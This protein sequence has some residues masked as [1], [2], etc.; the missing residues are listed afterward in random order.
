MIWFYIQILYIIYKN[1]YIEN[2]LGS[3][4]KRKM[5]MMNWDSI[6]LHLTSY[7]N[8]KFLKI[9]YLRKFWTFKPILNK[10]PTSLKFQQYSKY[11]LYVHF[12]NFF[13]QQR[14][15]FLH[16]TSVHIR[17]KNIILRYLIA[18]QWKNKVKRKQINFLYVQNCSV[19]LIWHM[20]S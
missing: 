15:A 10:Y 9:F 7:D 12:M 5:I 6:D 17:M 11:R 3:G 14:I 16:K 2:N 13:K 4:K 8:S 1:K 20:K 19:A 18:F